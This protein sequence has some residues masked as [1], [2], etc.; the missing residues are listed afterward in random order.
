MAHYV[1]MAL[2]SYPGT[3]A[4][5]SCR[6]STWRSWPGLRWKTPNSG[7]IGA[8]LAGRNMH[9][10]GSKWCLKPAHWWVIVISVGLILVHVLLSLS[11]SLTA[12]FIF[13]NNGDGLR[14]RLHQRCFSSGPA[15]E[16]RLG[17]G[18]SGL[19]LKAQAKDPE[20]A[21]LACLN[22]VRNEVVLDTVDGRCLCHAPMPLVL[23]GV[24]G[25]AL[26]AAA[27][28][29]VVLR[30]EQHLNCWTMQTMCKKCNVLKPLNFQPFP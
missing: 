21:T 25:R 15:S 16:L 28:A 30:W 14:C 1:T 10:D 7:F 12:F 26:A 24:A 17:C 22:L 8:I 9:L 23:A 4:S 2:G 29:V 3:V 13:A 11:L 20:L 18:T 5:R 19:R 27:A 6:G